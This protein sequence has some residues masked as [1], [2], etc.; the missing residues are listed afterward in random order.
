MGLFTIAMR[1][2]DELIISVNEGTAEKPYEIE[3]KVQI[4]GMGNGDN[5][6]DILCYVPVYQSSKR[7]FM[8]NR[9]H[10]RYYDFD[11]KFMGE[12]GIFIDRRF[13]IVKHMPVPD[14]TICDQCGEFFEYAERDEDSDAFLCWQCKQ[15]PYR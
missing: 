10:Q 12:Q 5:D 9:L 11:P 13:D 6:A 8:L 2:G 3:L 7:T 14:G 4:I 1:P 15:D